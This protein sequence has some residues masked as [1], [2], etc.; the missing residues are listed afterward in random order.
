MQYWADVSYNTTIENP[1][2]LLRKEPYKIVEAY[3]IPLDQ[4]IPSDNLN[5]KL[6][7]GDNV[8]W[9]DIT[10]AQAMAIIDNWKK[11]NK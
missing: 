7:T 1:S 10:E 9:E 11:Q 6:N 5:Y 3:S 8:F 2:L 4:W